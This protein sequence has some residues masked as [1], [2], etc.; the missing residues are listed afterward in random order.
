MTTTTVLRFVTQATHPPFGHR[1]GVFQ[2]A[3]EIHGAS[4]WM[5]SL[6]EQLQWFEQSLKTP[7]RL[8]VSR[9]PR[10]KETALSWVKATAIEH[11]ERLRALVSMVEAISDVRLEELRTDRPEY[12]VFEDEH[13]V[14]ALPF[15]DTPR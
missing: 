5:T 10:A 8:S 12:V 13:Q 1:T 3:Y 4:P 2:I 7:A 11:V 9:H 6:G 14:V 15:A